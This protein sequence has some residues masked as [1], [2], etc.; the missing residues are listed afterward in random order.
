MNEQ[1][2]GKLVEILA[3]IQNAAR[4][5]GDFA[6]REL[7][8]VAQSYVMYGRAI[9]TIALIFGVVI[10][11]GL[12]VLIVKKWEDVTG[13]EV[14]PIPVLLVGGGGSF[15]LIATNFAPT[16]LVWFA[17]KVWLLNEIASLSK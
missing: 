5:T 12:V 11:I 16:L 14:W 17:P 4:A 10:A 7:P 8:D 13:Y 3:S 1:L 6:M 9:H 2:Q 15:T